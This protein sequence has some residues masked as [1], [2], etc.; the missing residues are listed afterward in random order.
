M[1]IVL[2]YRLFNRGLILILVVF[3]LT[4]CV[5][6]K[7]ITCKSCVQMIDTSLQKLNGDYGIDLWYGTKFFPNGEI[8]KVKIDSTATVRLK[9]INR[10]SIRLSLYFKGQF[11]DSKIILGR[12]SQGYFGTRPRCLIAGIPPLFLIYKQKKNFLGVTKDGELYL[13]SNSYSII[14]IGYQWGDLGDYDYS[15]YLTK[16]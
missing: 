5:P 15:Y 13:G 12:V 1:N 9:V 14:G 16:K 3:Y 6:N 2:T 11:I 8:R 10:N 4:G 7:S